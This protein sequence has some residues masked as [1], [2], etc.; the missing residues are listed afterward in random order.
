MNMSKRILEVE[1]MMQGE[2]AFMSS[3]RIRRSPVRKAQMIDLQRGDNTPKESDTSQPQATQPVATA[4]QK[5]DKLSEKDDG[6]ITPRVSG[7]PDNRN[8]G[9]GQISTACTPMANASS[10]TAESSP[11]LELIGKM[12]RMEEDTMSQ[13]RETLDMMQRVTHR[14]KNISIDVKNGISRMTELLDVMLSY[15]RTWKAAEEERTTSNLRKKTATQQLADAPT[16]TTTNTKRAA[17]SPVV[18]ESC[19]KHRAKEPSKE[20]KETPQNKEE[21]WVTVTKKRTQKK[22]KEIS[23]KPGKDTRGKDKPR[24]GRTKPDALVI[25]PAEGHTYSDVLKSLRSKITTEDSDRIKAVRR[26]LTG[27]ILLEFSR[28]EK[29]KPEFVQQLRGTVQ[30]TAS[31]AELKQRATIEIRDLDSFTVK[32]EVETAIR[33]LIAD[34]NEQLQTRITVPN[35]REQVRAFITLSAES[36]ARLIKIGHVKVGWIRAKMRVCEG[37]RRCYRCLETGHSQANCSG[38]DRRDMCIKCGET[39]HKMRECRSAPKCAL[40]TDARRDRTDHL[41]GSKKCPLARRS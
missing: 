17:T 6:D 16:P 32:E 23:T 11:R 9:L 7:T 10:V 3:P 27:A 30:E 4:L 14:Q 8:I 36:A 39:G 1:E 12:R 21:N 37:I 18:A 38:P 25:K 15:R 34:P 31:I 35:V 33:K 19:K 2:V 29:V 40:C 41:P 13:C 28:G 20:K 5:E 24:L 22:P 26:T